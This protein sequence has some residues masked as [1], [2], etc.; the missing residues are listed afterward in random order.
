MYDI[1]VKNLHL[2]LDIDGV[3]T[4]DEVC[5]KA[6]VWVFCKKHVADYITVMENNFLRRPIILT[7][8]TLIKIIEEQHDVWT[9]DQLRNIIA[10][11]SSAAEIA[12]IEDVP[13]H[14]WPIIVDLKRMI[15]TAK[16]IIA[17]VRFHGVDKELSALL[18]GNKVALPMSN[19]IRMQH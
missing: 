14:I 18:V 16:N 4:L 2:A 7:E 5:A 17:Y 9:N 12:D 6:A 1:N 10:H 8:A 13:S 3:P 19:R 15:P 11:S